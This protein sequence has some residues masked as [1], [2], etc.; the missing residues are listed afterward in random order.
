MR[1]DGGPCDAIGCLARQVRCIALPTPVGHRTNGAAPVGKPILEVSGWEG[2]TRTESEPA[3]RA[4]PVELPRLKVFSGTANQVA[5]PSHA[6]RH[7]IVE[8][9]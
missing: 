7:L 1:S 8:L 3:L 4:A 9:G 5:A 2:A 6:G